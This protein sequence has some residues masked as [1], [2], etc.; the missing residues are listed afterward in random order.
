MANTVKIDLRKIGEMKLEGTN[1]LGRTMVMDAP[2]AYG[3]TDEG[4]RPI[5]ALLMSL[6]GCSSTDVL[7]IL[8]KKRQE[9][10]SFTVHVEGDRRDAVPAVFEQIR[11]HFHV[12]GRVNSED[13][14]SA[15]RVSAEKY[16]SVGA[17]LQAAGVQL[18]WTGTVE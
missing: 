17:M 3:G 13:L 5:E 15:I 9:V 6:A 10:S 18:T 16:C 4:V 1:A 7:T 11:V 2:V 8:A 14:D 12:Q